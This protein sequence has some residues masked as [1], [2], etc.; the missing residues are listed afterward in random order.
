MPRLDALLLLSFLL[1]STGAL[2]PALG[3]CELSGRASYVGLPLQRS[4]GAGSKRVGLSVD[5]YSCCGDLIP[6][7][8]HGHAAVIRAGA[9]S[10][11]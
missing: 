10:V 3:S 6:T 5:H 9:A 2:P 4:R 1:R 7:N 8:L 11:L